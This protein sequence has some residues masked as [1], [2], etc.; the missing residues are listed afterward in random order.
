LHRVDIF[1]W[2]LLGC[3]LSDILDGLIARTFHLTSKLGA[4]LDSIAD[5][6]TLTLGITGILVFQRAFVSAHFRVLLLVIVLHIV[7]VIAS[8]W[9]Y[10]KV[11]SFHALLTRI[12][13]YL[14]GIFAMSL[15][16]WGYL[17]WLFHTT[18]IVA[19][20]AMA[21][22]MALIYLLP[23][24]RSDVGGLHRVLP[25]LRREAGALGEGAGDE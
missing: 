20:L 22:E 17:G 15:F 21:E 11:S 19:V 24:W 3:L 4:S 10:G 14:Q 16:F 6:L 12:A 1:K 8:L 9:R 7:E 13:A 2:L 23:E 18:V 5:L 25:G